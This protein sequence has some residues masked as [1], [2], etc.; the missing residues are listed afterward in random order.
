MSTD[1]GPDVAG[2]SADVADDPSAADV[3]QDTVDRKSVV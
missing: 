3:S 2:D 1:A